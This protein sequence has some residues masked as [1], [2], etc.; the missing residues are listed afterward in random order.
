MESNELV[1]E[2]EF[3]SKDTMLN[4]WG[5]TQPLGACSP[6]QVNHDALPTSLFSWTPQNPYE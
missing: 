4:E 1:V 5:W 3:V 2:G 6:S